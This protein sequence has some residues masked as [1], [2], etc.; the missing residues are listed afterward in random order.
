MHLKKKVEGTGGVLAFKGKTPLGSRRKRKRVAEGRK[1]G[2]E[3]TG[4]IQKL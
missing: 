3:R 1:T 2:K 4:K